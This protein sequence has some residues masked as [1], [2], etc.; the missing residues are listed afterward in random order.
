MSVE[1]I[2]RP[3]LPM[4]AGLY[5]I[6]NV[7]SGHRYVGSSVNLRHRKHDHWSNLRLG[8]H[9][10]DR[11]QKAWRKYGEHA[12]V[13]RPLV[14][15]ER[16]RN[17]LLL[18]EQRLLNQVASLDSCYNICRSAESPRLGRRGAAW[19]EERRRAFSALMKAKG[20]S[21]FEARMAASRA[22]K[23]AGRGY[24]PQFRERQRIAQTGRKKPPRTPIHQARLAASRAK[25]YPGFVAP[26]GT[27]H[28]PVTNLS[29]FAREHGLHGPAMFEVA[30]GKRTH[31]RQWRALCP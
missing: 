14:I 8:R 16:D 10:N 23:A 12:F 22:A 26:D 19:T 24:G 18:M 15:T 21:L 28:S 6:V 7:V 31:Y 17:L 2:R 29:A 13:F 30:H 11:L 5:E 4:Q 27:V 25:T 3:T 9:R 20:P 1:A